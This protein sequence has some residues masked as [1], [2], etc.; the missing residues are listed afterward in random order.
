MSLNELPLH[1]RREGAGGWVKNNLYLTNITV[2]DLSL[3]SS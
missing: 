1:T 2:P 3:L